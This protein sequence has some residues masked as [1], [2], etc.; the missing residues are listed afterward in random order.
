MPPGSAAYSTYTL[1][2]QSNAVLAIHFIVRGILIFVHWQ[3]GRV[4][5]S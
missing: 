3:Q 4:F 1:T 5:P 2:S